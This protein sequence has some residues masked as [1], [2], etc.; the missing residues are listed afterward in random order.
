MNYL[1]L[2]DLEAYLFR[3][4]R[5][6]FRENGYLPAFDFFCIVIW[7]ANRA[8]SKL[9]KRLLA[10]GYDNLETA[11]HDLTTGLSRQQTP[12]ERLRY[13]W[14][15]SSWGFYLP[16]ASAILTVLY[17]EDFTVYDVRV[18]EALNDFHS[19]GAVSNFDRLWTQYQNFKSRVEQATPE[20]L[21][22]RDKDRYLWAK[23]FHEQLVTDVWSGFGKRQLEVPNVETDWDTL[24]KLIDENQMDTGISDLAHQHDHY[25]HG[26]PKREVGNDTDH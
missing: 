4:V 1:A 24:T 18:C 26:T 23:S 5:E 16:M 6:K 14:D 15:G 12:K 3:D 10:K 21:T 20:G 19:L 25:I 8:K 2:Y 7:K 11:V 17:P 13:L 9:A 22:L